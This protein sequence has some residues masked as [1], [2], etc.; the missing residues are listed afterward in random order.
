M[1]H[2]IIICVSLSI[3]T[4]FAG[5]YEGYECTEDCSGHRAG[6]E[7][8]QENDINEEADC[9]GKSYSFEEGCRAFTENPDRNRTDL[10][11]DGNYIED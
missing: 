7:W 2:V 11:D 10:D 9:V 6:Y 5:T 4:A 8:A 1:R 3:N